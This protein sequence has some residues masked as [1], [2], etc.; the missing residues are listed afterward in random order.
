MVSFADAL[1]IGLLAAEPG[2]VEALPAAGGRIGR[3]GGPQQSGGISSLR[4]GYTQFNTKRLVDIDDDLLERARSVAGT[5]TIKE[6]VN[7]ELERLADDEK[8]RRQALLFCEDSGLRLPTG[9]AWD[10]PVETILE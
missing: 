4:I 6:T 10:Y 2:L 1:I 5:K 7:T 3:R 8:V 9:N